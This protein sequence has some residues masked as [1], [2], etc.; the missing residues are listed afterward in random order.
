MEPIVKTA[1]LLGITIDPSLMNAMVRL[2]EQG[3]DPR[4]VVK[5]YNS[6]RQRQP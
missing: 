3:S 4:A 2:V 1:R 5:V 6:I